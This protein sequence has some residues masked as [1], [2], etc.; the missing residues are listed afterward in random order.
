MPLY[1]RLETDARVLEYECVEF[2]EQL[3]FGELGLIDPES[4]LPNE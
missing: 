3:M 2:V 4:G 1:R